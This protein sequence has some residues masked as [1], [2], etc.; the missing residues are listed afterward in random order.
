MVSRLW[1]SPQFECRSRH[2]ER[3]GENSNYL[4]SYNGVCFLKFKLS[5]GDVSYSKK[6]QWRRCSELMYSV[7]FVTISQH[8]KIFFKMSA[9]LDIDQGGHEKCTD[10]NILHCMKRT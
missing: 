6:F 7:I 5:T 1:Y 4:F 2:L 9:H 10:E 3:L 8:L